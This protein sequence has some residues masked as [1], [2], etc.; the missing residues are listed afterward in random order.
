LCG[1]AVAVVIFCIQIETVIGAHFFD[2]HAIA[3]DGNADLSSLPVTILVLNFAVAAE[4]SSKSRGGNQTH[5]QNNH[6]R[7]FHK[8]PFLIYYP[9]PDP[10]NSLKPSER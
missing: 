3:I 6:Q 7:L 4:F 10:R 2:A 1:W 8:Y 5:H 9:V